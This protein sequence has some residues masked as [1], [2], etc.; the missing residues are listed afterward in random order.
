L[1]DNG[2]KQ[3]WGL[4]IVKMLQDTLVMFKI[5][6]KVVVLKWDVAYIC[7]ISKSH[8]LVEVIVV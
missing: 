5:K 2:S 3:V 1:V 4:L 8:E 6:K 7:P